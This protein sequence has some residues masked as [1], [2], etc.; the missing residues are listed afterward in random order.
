MHGDKDTWAL[1]ALLA[2]ITRP[3]S[4]RAKVGWL[5]RASAGLLSKKFPGLTE[6]FSDSSPG[7]SGSLTEELGSLTGETVWGHVQMV[8]GQPVSFNWQPHYAKGFV[9]FAAAAKQP[10][11]FE[12]GP[13]DISSR[14]FGES[15]HCC[16]QFA[17]LRNGPHDVPSPPLPLRPDGRAP[18]GLP[19]RMRAAFAAAADALAIV[20]SI[21]NASGP[22]TAQSE[23]EGGSPGMA[24]A[25]KPAGAWSDVALR[26]LAVYSGLTFAALVAACLRLPSAFMAV[27]AGEGGAE[28]AAAI[29]GR[30]PILL[31]IGAVALLTLE[32][33]KGIKVPLFLDGALGALSRVGNGGRGNALLAAVEACEAAGGCAALIASTDTEKSGIDNS[34]TGRSDTGRAHSGKA[35]S[36]AADT[37]RVNSERVNSVEGRV[38]LWASVVHVTSRDAAKTD[39]EL[40]AWRALGLTTR[41]ADDAQARIDVALAASQLDLPKALGAYDRVPT[42]VLRADLWRLAIVWLRGGIYAD[43]DVDPTPRMQT[44]L[45]A[46]SAMPAL[47]VPDEVQHGVSRQNSTPGL[48]LFVENWS[49]IPAPIGRLAIAIG[50]SDFARFPQYR[51]CIFAAQSPKHPLLAA[52]FKLA[53]SRLEEQ[54]RESEKL[55]PDAPAPSDARVLELTGPGL[56]TDAT[57][58][59]LNAQ[60]AAA[61][62]VTSTSSGDHTDAQARTDVVFIDRG[63]G[64]S[65]FIH[66]GVGSWKSGSVKSGYTER[67]LLI[68]VGVALAGCALACALAPARGSTKQPRRDD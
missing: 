66:A 52:A 61:A 49:F 57:D 56:L 43:L 6:E 31:A 62:A 33:G 27:R 8:D 40:G 10:V 16:A 37:G 19:P 25:A 60:A 63:S 34:D 64:T 50:L 48:L 13:K 39:G 67:I 54:E 15:L 36:G 26:K 30:R 59:F 7:E 44:L 29:K 55:G 45:Q 3:V 24:M 5:V 58:A 9:D 20:A 42:P 14:W 17:T 2:G 46:L 23:R 68:I 35:D 41:V 21:E 28:A 38:Q 32:G 18:A 4:P 53:I 65:F 22:Q 12:V 11:S 51:N 47:P 1:G